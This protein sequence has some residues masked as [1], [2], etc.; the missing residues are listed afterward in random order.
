MTFYR[1]VAAQELELL[2]CNGSLSPSERHYLPYKP[3]EI[4]FVFEAD[5]FV[6]LLKKYGSTLAEMRGMPVGT[7]LSILEVVGSIGKV[8]VDQSQCGG[9]PES[10]A[11]FSAI[12]IKNVNVVAEVAVR[13]ANPGQFVLG[14]IHLLGPHS[15]P[16]SHVSV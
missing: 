15:S 7:K 13:K 4:I 11:V 12:P 14:T 16:G 9:W 2:R 3:G 1:F 8:E 5:D 10:R 6:D